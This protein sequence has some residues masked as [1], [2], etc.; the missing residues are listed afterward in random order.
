M[1]DFCT[2]E[3]CPTQKGATLARILSAARDEFT[4]KGFD[5]SRIESVARGANV[6]KQLVHHYFQSKAALYKAVLE[7]TAKTASSLLDRSGYETLDPKAAIERFVNLIFDL[8]IKHPE[9]TTLSLDQALHR[10][11]QISI[12]TEFVP[13]TRSFIKEV[14]SPILLQGAEKGLFRPDVDA[15][16]FYASVYHLVASCF[17]MGAATTLTLGVDMD[18]PKGIEAWREHVME[19]TL[20]ALR[21]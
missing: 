1:D 3:N 2:T 6:T 9:L 17:Y 19:F 4:E 18:S 8:H 7:M 15:F 5:A 13:L 16:L 14:I 21:A 12:E 11:A 10:A 20:A